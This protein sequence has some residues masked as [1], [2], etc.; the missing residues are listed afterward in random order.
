MTIDVVRITDVRAVRST[1]PRWSC[2]GSHKV[3]GVS[4]AGPRTRSPWRFARRLPVPIVASPIVL[5]HSRNRSARGELG[6]YRKTG[7]HVSDPF[8]P[9][10]LS[11]GTG[12]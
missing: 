6:S 11:R 4:T 2:L 12:G 5:G 7:S 1:R 8:V 10:P 3:S 9:M